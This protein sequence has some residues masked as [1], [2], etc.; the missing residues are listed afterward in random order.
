MSSGGSRLLTTILVGAALVACTTNQPSS[1][2]P[3]STDRPNAAT[4]TSLPSPTN[5][6]PTLAPTPSLTPGTPSPTPTQTSSASPEATQTAGPSAGPEPQPPQIVRWHIIDDAIHIELFNSNYRFGLLRAE[7]SIDVLGEDGES[8]AVLGQSGLPGTPASTILQ[9]PPRGAYGL[10]DFLPAGAPAVGALELELAPVQWMDWSEVNPPAVEITEYLLGASGLRPRVTGELQILGGDGPFNV[11]AMAF[12]EGTDAFV[13]V[14]GVVECA[15]PETVGPFELDALSD[16]T[17]G[18]V[19][20][21]DA[22]V[23][24]VPGVPGSTDGLD[25]PPGC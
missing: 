8:I 4:P 13:V 14:D 2:N 17:A 16:F 5:S 11:W 3:T 23:T 20:R 22:Y 25:A 6:A 10:L 1:P 15:E 12:V 19:S 9:L 18:T 24:T 7:F 21:I